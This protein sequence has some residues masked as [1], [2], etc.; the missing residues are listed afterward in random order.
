MRT[1]LSEAKGGELLE[2]RRKEIAG[3][4]KYAIYLIGKISP[5][6]LDTIQKYL[7]NE[8]WKHD[9][10]P[11]ETRLW[12]L[13]Y[14]ISKSPGIPLTEVTQTFADSIGIKKNT[15]KKFRLRWGIKRYS[16]KKKVEPEAEQEDISMVF[17]DNMTVN[18]SDQNSIT[19]N[20]PEPPAS[21]STAIADALDIFSKYFRD[22]SL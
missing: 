6:P 9:R 22:K 21:F 14:L 7:E 19:F 1:P 15:A 17:K 18:T 5:I 20:T 16:R 10:T 2:K 11:F 12:K 13:C 8:L 4:E 3:S